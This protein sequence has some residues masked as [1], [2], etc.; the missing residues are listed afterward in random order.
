MAFELLRGLIGGYGHK[1]EAYFLWFVC[2]GGGVFLSWKCRFKMAG[3]L[4]R[5]TKAIHKKP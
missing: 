3:V 5:V 2:F 4:I 1:E